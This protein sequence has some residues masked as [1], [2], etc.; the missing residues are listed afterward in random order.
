M[1]GNLQFQEKN[2]TMKLG[3]EKFFRFR[4]IHSLGIWHPENG[5]LELSSSLISDLELVYQE[6]I[7]D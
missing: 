1:C 6:W 2:L 5:T 7:V 3:K 4:N